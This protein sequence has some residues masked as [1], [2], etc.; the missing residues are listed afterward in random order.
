MREKAVFAFLSFLLLAAVRLSAGTV[1]VVSANP[2][3]ADSVTLLIQ[4]NSDCFL[5]SVTQTGNLFQIHVGICSFEPPA[6]PVPL[7][8][9]PQGS[10][11]YEIYE[12]PGTTTLLASGSFVVTLLGVP[13]LSTAGLAALLVCLAAAGCFLTRTT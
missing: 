4:N 1:A 13:T 2:T 8:Q 3:T 11:Q 9:L 6:I 7:G 5:Q 10:Y 12:G